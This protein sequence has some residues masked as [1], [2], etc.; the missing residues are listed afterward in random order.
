MP[1]IVVATLDSQISTLLAVQHGLT[2]IGSMANESEVPSKRDILVRSAIAAS[3]KL[4]GSLNIVYEGFRARH[5][6]RMKEVVDASTDVAGLPLLKARL[7]ASEELDVL[8]AAALEA[9]AISAL[10]RKRSLLGKVVGQAA[11]DDALID[12]VSLTVGVLSQ[13]DAA[14]VRCLAAIK[15]AEDEATAKGEV[16]TRAD[17]AERE[18]VQR[19]K[20]AGASYPPPVIALLA[21]LGLV[22]ATGTATPWPL[23]LGLTPFGLSLL[24]DLSDS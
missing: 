1:H 6:A 2:I 24:E 4:A 17:F 9:G 16:R 5:V 23:V 14:H 15:L 11:A 19:I 7:E 20:N 13:I 21:G 10:S 22:E 8:F 12:E 18:I 3:P